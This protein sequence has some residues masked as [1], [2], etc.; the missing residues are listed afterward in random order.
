MSTSI[1]RFYS[2]LLLWSGHLD[3]L[4]SLLDGR[5]YVL[6]SLNLCKY[7]PGFVLRNQKGEKSVYDPMKTK[8]G[9]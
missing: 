6:F 5:L 4:E 7:E 1:G 3:G 9:V 2:P 8:N